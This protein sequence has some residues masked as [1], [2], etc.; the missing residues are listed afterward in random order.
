VVC[1]V[2]GAGLAAPLVRLKPMA[3]IKG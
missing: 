1:A 3:V 2:E